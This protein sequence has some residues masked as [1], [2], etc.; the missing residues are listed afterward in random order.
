MSE[1]DVNTYRLQLQQVEAA[2]TTDPDNEELLQLKTD[3]EQVLNLTMEM[4]NDAMGGGGEE[5]GTSAGGEEADKAE[6]DMEAAFNKPKKKSRWAEP[7]PILPIKPWQVGEVCQ[8]LYSGKYHSNS[9]HYGSLLTFIIL[10]V[11]GP[12]MM[13]R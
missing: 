3:L 2:L 9:I 11:M 8:A 13:R 7:A 12:T 4:L 6:D 5:A 1:A 10:Q